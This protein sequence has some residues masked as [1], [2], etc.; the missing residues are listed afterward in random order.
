MT[1]EKKEALLSFIIGFGLFVFTR[2]SRIVPTI[3][4]SILIAPVFI[5]RFI[6]LQPPLRGN[7][8]TFAGIIGVMNFALI[9][10]FDMGGGIAS[11]LFN[12]IRSTLLALLYYLPYLIDRRL[13]PRYKNIG[14]F[15][16][17]I[18]PVATTA[19]FYVLTLE[20]PFEGSYQMGKFLYGPIAFK[21]IASLAGLPGAVFLTSWFASVVNYIREQDQQWQRVKGVVLSYAFIAAAVLAFGLI[22]SFPAVPASVETVRTGSI[23][24]IPE[25]G[26]AVD[27]VGLMENRTTHDIDS[28][29]QE[30]EGKTRLAA[31][32]GAKIVMS[33][34]L[35]FLIN[36]SDRAE[37]TERCRRLADDYDVYLAMNYGYYVEEG[38]GENLMLFIDDQGQI[39]IEYPKKYLLGIGDVGET[40]VFKKGPELLQY[41]DTP[42]GR[43]SFAICRENDMAKY[44]IQAGR[45]DVDIMISPAYEWPE[46]LE[47]NIAYMRGIEN[48]YSVIRSSYNGITYASDYNGRI[49]ATMPF[50]PDETGVMFADV[51]VKGVRTLYPFIGASLA[52]LCIIALA[53]FSVVALLLRRTRDTVF[54]K[55]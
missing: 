19:V 35:V 16:T 4:V 18:F 29:F 3:P 41:A 44:M 46:N 45:N 43:I 20:G 23:V 14:G 7:L 10:L 1:K 51:P 30:F 8:L 47:I 37:F 27:L 15:A 26:K 24:L 28:R 36:E 42:Y 38:K 40:L 17:L 55:R 6:R 31:S 48:G 50:S 53:G 9:G 21:Q 32:G 5:L 34:E 54:D 13:Y 2:M 25:D 11:L 12:L 49:L 52:W 33:H 22:K 39:L